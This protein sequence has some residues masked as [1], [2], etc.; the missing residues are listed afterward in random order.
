MAHCRVSYKN[1]EGLHSVEVTAET[2][3]EAGVLA[4]VE[5]KEDK[6]ISTPPAPET[7]LR[8]RHSETSRTHHTLEARS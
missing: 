1:D 7:E 3:Y 6:T 8:S 4:I 2:L 5:F